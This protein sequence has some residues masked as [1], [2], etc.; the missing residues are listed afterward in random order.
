MQNEQKELNDELSEWADKKCILWYSKF[1]LSIC[2]HI[3]V[4]TFVI[5]MYF[6]WTDLQLMCFISYQLSFLL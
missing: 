3:S 2:I 1:D 4:K 5:Q 6:F